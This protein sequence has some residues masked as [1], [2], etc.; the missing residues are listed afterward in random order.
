L[1]LRLCLILLTGLALALPVCADGP[2]ET[3]QGTVTWVHDGDTVEIEKLGRVRLIGIDTP[4]REASPRDAFLERQGVSAMRQ[5]EIY[6]QA[7]AFN[8]SY[9]K[10]Q[11]V[12]LTFDHPPRDRYGRLLAYVYLPDGRLLNRILLERGLAVVYRKFTFRMKPD[13]LAAEEQAKQ[14]GVGLWDG[15]NL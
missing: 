2:V 7:K 14:A 8:I 1:I 5:R 10:G 15:S 9:V 6:R 3:L 4:E 12:V 11:T 13:F